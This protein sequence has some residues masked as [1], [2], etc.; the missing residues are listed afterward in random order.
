MHG[1][2]LDS[3]FELVGGDEN[4]MTAALGWCM[5]HVP[6]LLSQVAAELGCPV[7]GDTAVVSLQKHRVAGGFTDIEVEDAGVAA[8]IIEA[9]QGF[10]APQLA[11]LEKYAVRLTEHPDAAAHKVLAV[12]GRSDRKELWL[13][14]QTPTSALGIPVKV[15]SWAQIIACAGR[16]YPT[17]DNTGKA[18]LRHLTVFLEKGLN[19]Q[20]VNSNETLRRLGEQRRF[21]R[22]PHHLHRRGGQVRQ[23]LPSRRRAVARQS[24]QLHRLQVGWT[25]PVGS[26]RRQLRGYYRLRPAL[27]WN[28]PGRDRPAF[29]LPSRK[30]SLLA[31]ERAWVAFREKDAAFRATP[32]SQKTGTLAGV[33]FAGNNVAQI[34]A[35]VYD[36][37]FYISGD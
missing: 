15:L 8:W 33:V 20:V 18:L 30:A 21:Q 3:L 17:T 37:E 7:P 22:R 29:S 9:K 34:K 31:A 1:R 16:A 26:S 24:A 12:L 14:L 2:P 27:P 32:W 11:Q 6:G 13:K 23:V 10:K 5:A 25:P 35:R 4:A 19:M 36:L 28:Y